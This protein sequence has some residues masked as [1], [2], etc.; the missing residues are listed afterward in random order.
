MHK[1]LMS[2]EEFLFTKLFCTI[3]PSNP[4]GGA[5]LPPTPY[6]FSAVNFLGYIFLYRTNLKNYYF[7]VIQTMANFAKVGFQP[8]FKTFQ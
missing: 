5:D 8:Y 7:D 2:K 4:G 6:D 3:N 1:S